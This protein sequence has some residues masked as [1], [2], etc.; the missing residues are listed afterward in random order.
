MKFTFE[1]ISVDRTIRSAV[2]VVSKWGYMSVDL[3]V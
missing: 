2:G 1:A 3:S